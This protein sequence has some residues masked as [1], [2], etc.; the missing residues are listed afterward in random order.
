M[1]ATVGDVMTRKV[2]AVRAEADYKLLVSVLRQYR[3]SACPVVND[4]CQ[5]MGV[6]SEDD[7]LC[8]IAAPDLPGELSRLRWQL[9]T[10]GKENAVTAAALMT[11]PAITIRSDM[12]VTAAA[13]AMRDHK[14]RRLP[15]VDL[16]HRLIGIVSR[17]DVL[18][19][20]ERSDADIAAD[21]SAIISGEIGQD[22]N[23]LEVSVSSGVV[24]V[25]GVVESADLA[26]RVL[27]RTSHS[28]GVVAV[29]D[30]LT[31]SSAPHPAAA[32]TTDSHIVVAGS[33]GP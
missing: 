22:G 6:V 2:V 15:V 13:K 20:F 31:V 27:A 12:P 10:D 16:Q 18:S 33:A 28:E 19:V 26:A 3:I 9:G 17:A 30:R 4:R 23:D 5:V 7:L 24:T 29:R 21:V 32:N 1:T 25:G 14:L 8:K 11:S